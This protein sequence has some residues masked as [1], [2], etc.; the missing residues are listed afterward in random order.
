MANAKT[1]FGQVAATLDN[2]ALGLILDLSATR[3]LDSSGLQAL[4][5]LVQ[6]IRV[7]GQEVRVVAPVDSPARRL[8]EA[9]GA[10]DSVSLHAAL[11]EAQDARP[12]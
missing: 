8:I 7:R 12:S 1:V 9:V 5:D 3:Y 10:Q 2:R 4:L 6:R 11:A